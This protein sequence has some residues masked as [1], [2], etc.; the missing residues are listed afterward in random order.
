MKISLSIELFMDF[1]GAELYTWE[2]VKQ[3]EAD[4]L[5]LWRVCVSV[6]V[7]ERG[8]DHMGIYGTFCLR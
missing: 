3:F 5:G 7:R 1:F 6:C 8:R 4:V 2:P